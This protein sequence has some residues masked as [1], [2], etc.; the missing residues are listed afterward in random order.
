MSFFLQL[1]FI[2][3]KS[4]EKKYLFVLFV[5]LISFTKTFS[6][7]ISTSE[8]LTATQLV[9]NVLFNT[10]CATVTNV[11]VSGGNFISGEKSWGYFNVNGSSFPFSDGIILSTGR[12]SNAV[13]PNSFI[14]D[15]GGSMGWG[16]D[17]DLNQALSIFNTMNATVLE[18]DFVPYGDKI[19]FDYIFA[20]EEY[21]DTATCIYSDGF[22]FL[23]KAVG[24][25]SYQN[26]AL[27]PNTTIPVKVTTVH[28]EIP[29]SCAAQNEQ[30]FGSFNNVN[31]PT[32]FNGQTAILTAKADVIPGTSYHIKLVIADEGNYRYDSAIFLK[33]SSF[34]FGVDLGADRLFATQN[35]VCPNETIT[36][37]ATSTATNYQWNFNGNPIPGATNSTYT[38]TP[39]YTSTQDGVYSVDVTYNPTCTITSD[40]TL[41]FSPDLIINQQVYDFCD[42]DEDGITTVSLSSIIPTLYSNLPANFTVNFYESLTSTTPLPLSFQNTIPFSQTIFA[43]VANNSCYTAIPVTLNM[44]TFGATIADESIGIC[45]G[46]AATLVA[47]SGFASYLW[48]TGEAPQSISVSS[49]GTYTVVI[50]NSNGCTKTKTF[51]VVTS[52]IATIEA[53]VINGLDE[54]NSVE[55]IVSGN[56]NYLY[57]LDGVNYQESNVFYNLNQGD[58]FVFV[59]DTNQCGTAGKEFTM[60]GI[61]KFFTPNDDGINDYWNIKGLKTA[62]NSKSTVSIF[63]RYGKLIKQISA[64]GK[65]WDGKVNGT[66]SPSDDYWFFVTLE[67]GNTAKGH[68][69]LKR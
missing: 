4:N 58:Y 66:L 43:K 63:N 54:N 42:T 20:S 19:S 62:T 2:T 64:V 47:D 32:N 31:H 57:S 21:H 16:T 52:E 41:E 23:L 14:S 26:L 3:T 6:Q 65:G 34:N 30:Y 37:N 61:P 35:P 10:S 44:L 67:D 7:S 68:F 22:A 46:N 24:G 49:A 1:E 53:I 28:P 69:A 11:S 18:F 33:G 40:I 48:N 27:I 59:F 5:I 45:N 51:T 8:S 12:I 38:L 56:G 50:E 39:P 13:G 17:F 60:I 15:D 9:E 29:G 55:I 36:L 25:S